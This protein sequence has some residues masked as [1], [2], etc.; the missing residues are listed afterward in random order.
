M[1]ATQQS[2]SRSSAAAAKAPACSEVVDEEHGRRRQGGGAQEEA[3]NKP[4]LRRG[5]WTVDEDLTL[6]NYIADNGE[7]RWNN[8]ARAAGNYRA[9]RPASMHH[10]SSYLSIRRTIG[11]TD[12]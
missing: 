6:V 11:S 12:D 7:G 5:P 2:R 1:A 9:R 10:L 4:E 8:L 3:E